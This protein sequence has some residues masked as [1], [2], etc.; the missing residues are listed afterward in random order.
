MQTNYTNMPDIN[1]AVEM[2]NFSMLLEIFKRL[3]INMSSTQFLNYCQS[4]V[5]YSAI[6]F[7][8]KIVRW[9][10]DEQFVTSMDFPQNVITL[11]NPD[12]IFFFFDII[13]PS[14]YVRN[15]AIHEWVKPNSFWRHNY[16]QI[17]NSLEIPTS[18]IEIIQEYGYPSEMDM[19]DVVNT[20]SSK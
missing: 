12:P 7:N 11:H 5:K 15:L 2:G 4:F 20:V 6:N 16:K 18:L 14:S 13:P 19:L 9:M 3:K 1:R 17:L 8:F 10:F